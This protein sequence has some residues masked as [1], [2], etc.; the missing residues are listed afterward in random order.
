MNY[1]INTRVSLTKRNLSAKLS[2]VELSLL[3]PPFYR[4]LVYPWFIPGV[5]VWGEAPEGPTYP[6]KFPKNKKGPKEIRKCCIRSIIF[7]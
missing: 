5:G 1:K 3:E 6:L 4:S 2:G 7:T